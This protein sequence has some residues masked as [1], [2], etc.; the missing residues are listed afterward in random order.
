MND[1]YEIVKYPRIKY[2]NA[3]LVD[4]SHRNS[5]L[6]HDFEICVLL[7]GKLAVN[8]KKENYELDPHSLIL[9]NPIQ[10]HE[11]RAPQGSAL[12]LSL[13]MSPR[14]CNSYYPSL[15]NVLFDYSN[16]ADILTAEDARSVLSILIELSLA[17]FDKGSAY[18]FVCQALINQ[19]LYVLL[20]RVPY[21]QI[22]D[23]ERAKN[24]QRLNRMNRIMSHIEGNYTSKLLLSTIAER[25]NLSLSYLSHFFKENLNMTFQDYLNQV[26]FDKA[27]QLIAHTNMKLIDVC[28]ESG[29]SDTRYLN[30]MFVKHFGCTP[31]EFRENNPHG[32]SSRPNSHAHA[33]QRFYTDKESHDRVNRHR[34]ALL[35]EGKLATA[36]FDSH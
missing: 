14:F 33:N 34:R 8:T 13:Q 25:E 20:Q 3:F 12:V 24:V 23:E 26:R 19:L 4:L 5:H 9:F 7:E 22:S 28:L 6:H 32:D 29:F 30:S 16:L 11:L 35:N 31:K 21:R 2:M 15:S 1:E 27:K 17:Y 36:L 18:E 10:P